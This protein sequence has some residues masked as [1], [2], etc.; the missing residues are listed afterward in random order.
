MFILDIIVDVVD[1][2]PWLRYRHNLAVCHVVSGVDNHVGLLIKPPLLT[3]WVDGYILLNE[4]GESNN[5]MNLLQVCGNKRASSFNCTIGGIDCLENQLVLVVDP[6]GMT[7][8]RMK[9]LQNRIT[10]P[11]I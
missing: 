2:L 6:Q 7:R 5:H 1:N 3:V 8:K 4:P 11:K 10:S 9:R